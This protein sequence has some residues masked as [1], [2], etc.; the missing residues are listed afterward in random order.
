MGY[1]SSSG[2]LLH[3][4]GVS[5]GAVFLLMVSR[6]ACHILER[7]TDCYSNKPLS[8]ARRGLVC[9]YRNRLGSDRVICS[10]FPLLQDVGHV[11]SLVLLEGFQMV[12]SPRTLLT[13]RLQLSY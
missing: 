9:C 8:V 4:I 6:V 2:A 1:W 10:C 7:T 3:R 11:D 13:R 12:L 5:R